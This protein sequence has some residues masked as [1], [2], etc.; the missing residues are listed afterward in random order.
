M[1]DLGWKALAPMTEA[2]SITVLSWNVNNR[3]CVAEGIQECL[4]G[5][6]SDM[7]LISLQEHF[8]LRSRV[9]DA[10]SKVLPAHTMV[11]V[12]RVCGLWSL[13]LSK[14]SCSAHAVRM[15]LGMLGFI[16]KGA[17]ITQIS[18]D[19]VFISCHLAPHLRNNKARLEQIQRIFEYV[20]TEEA[21]KRVA[22][23]VLA[24]DLNFRI[25]SAKSITDYGVAREFD[26]SRE[27]SKLYSSFREGDI[28]FQPTYKY[29]NNTD[30]LSR[31]RH[32]SW[33]DRVFVSSAH[34][35]AFNKYV[36]VR[37]VMSSDHR[38]VLSVFR[39]CGASGH[40]AL[41][42]VEH[43]PHTVNRGLTVLYCASHEFMEIILVL[44]LL[45]ALYLLS[46]R[47]KQSFQ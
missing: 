24:G 7:V 47:F 40:K 3:D 18:E 11:S 23:V 42:D 36:S 38:P 4:N 46:M 45:L 44:V 13:V 21:Q 2:V 17:C 10:V 43:R 1:R 19:L 30:A 32:P 8:D 22:T 26:Q 5:C 9:P 25:S 35:I 20:C 15:G 31:K 41:P 29:I 39:L 14:K 33:C 28:W 27:F 12:S 6:D 37:D 16:N 34:E